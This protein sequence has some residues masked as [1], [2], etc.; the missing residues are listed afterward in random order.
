VKT[1][2]KWSTPEPPSV[3]D[4]IAAAFLDHPADPAFGDDLD[5][6]VQDIR[7]GRTTWS[8]SGR[9][10][11]PPGPPAVI[12]APGSVISPGAAFG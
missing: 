2:V 12:A 10:P 7:P 8:E 6:V 5:D 1:G 11:D 3:A 9:P 4:A